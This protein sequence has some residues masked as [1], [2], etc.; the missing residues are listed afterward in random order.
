MI[1]I[2]LFLMKVLHY[3][4]GFKKTIAKIKKRTSFWKEPLD[5]KLF[6]RCYVLKFIFIANN[7]CIFA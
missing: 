1:W 6:L 7:A 5:N 2:T 3:W 4:I